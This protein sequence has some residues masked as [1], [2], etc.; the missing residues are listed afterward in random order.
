M[1]CRRVLACFLACGL[2]FTTSALAADPVSTEKLTIT[3]GYQPLTPTWGISIIYQAKLWKKYLPNVEVDRVNFMSGMPLVNTLVAGKLD[4]G[5][6]GDMP[7]I[8]LAS[9]S[10]LQPTQFIAVTDADHGGASEIYVAKDSTIKSVKDLSGKRVSIPFGGYTHR[11]AEVL[12]AK[13]GIK[14][15]FVGQSPEV[16][17]TNLQAGK[18]D[19]YI[20]W[21]P[22][23][24]LAVYKGFARKLADGTKYNFDALRGVVVTKEFAD[25]HPKVMVGWLRA[26]L[27]AHKIMRERPDYAAQLLFNEWSA[28]GIPL[29][30]IR[31]DFAFKVF[32][33]EITPEWRKVLTDGADFLRSHKFISGDID[34]NKYIDDSYLK[35]A[36][37]VPSQLEL[38]ALPEQ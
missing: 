3:M 1:K 35:K 38:S 29:S 9:K 25:Q 8:V 13:E 16:G 26:E 21:P 20:P 37:A 33:D 32:P 28:Y 24:E 2:L 27:D 5:Y 12:E 4:M 31:G 17:L 30:V 15:E 19:A 11:F 10:A 22:Y 7:A 6:L 34:F 23:G 14:F 18:V 36:A